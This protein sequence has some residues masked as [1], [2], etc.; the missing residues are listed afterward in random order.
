MPRLF[1]SA[2]RTASSEVTWSNGPCE[3]TAAAWAGVGVWGDAGF[4]PEADTWRPEANTQ[5]ISAA[6]AAGRK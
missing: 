3:I 5:K 6:I 4:C 1:S 2:I